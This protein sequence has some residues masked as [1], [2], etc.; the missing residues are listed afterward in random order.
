M[1]FMNEKITELL[2]QYEEDI[3]MT[4]GDLFDAVEEIMADYPDDDLTLVVHKY[5]M[6]ERYDR[7]FLG[8]RGDMDSEEE[9]FLMALHSRV[10]ELPEKNQEPAT[11]SEAWDYTLIKQVIENKR[12]YPAALIEKFIGAATYELPLLEKAGYTL[13]GDSYVPPAES[14]SHVK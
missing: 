3:A 5:R 2:L 14:N 6:A 12:S 8:M 13:Q 10:G 11:S 1:G 9:A 7:E 4:F